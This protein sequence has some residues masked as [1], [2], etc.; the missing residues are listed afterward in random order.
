MDMVVYQFNEA[1]LLSTRVLLAAL[2]HPP[3]PPPPR[4]P[5]G[6]SLSL[7]FIFLSIYLFTYLSIYLA[8]PYILHP[9]CISLS[10]SLTLPPFILYASLYLSPLQLHPTFHMHL[11]IYLAYPYTLHPICSKG[12]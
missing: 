8:Y 5:L 1:T 4:L 2:S 11:A 7:I 12:K 10:T 6:N 9:V 3:P